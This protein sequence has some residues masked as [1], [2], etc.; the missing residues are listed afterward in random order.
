MH[1]Y[2]PNRASSTTFE[3]EPSGCRVSS[4]RLAQKARQGPFPVWLLSTSCIF[5]SHASPRLSPRLFSAQP[6]VV[7]PRATMWYLVEEKEPPKFPAQRKAC[8][9]YWLGGVRGGGRTIGRKHVDIRLKASSV[10]RTHARINVLK[11]AFYSP[12]SFGRRRHYST[13]VSVQDSSAY[14][15]FVKYPPGHASNRS[16]QAIGHHRRLDK[17][18]PTEVCEGALLAFGAPSSWWRLG[19]EHIVLVYTRISA[20]ERDRITLI[21]G[22]TAV[23]VAD[24]WVVGCT[25]LVTHECISSSMTFLAVL[26]EGKYVITP[27]WVEALRHTVTEACRAVTEAAN[28]EAAM[29]ACTLADE[30]RFIP[31]FSPADQ[32]AFSAEE[33]NAV[34]EPDVKERRMAMFK[35]IVFAFTREER[36]SRWVAVIETL[37]G[38]TMLARAVKPAGTTD[39]IVFV[40]G[41]QGASKKGLDSLDV[42]GHAYV[43]ESALSAAI[44]RADLSP[45]EDATS[46]VKPAVAEVTD[47]ATPGPL[48]SESE[49]ETDDSEPSGPTKRRT[50]GQGSAMEVEEAIVDVDGVAAG[51][52]DL[53]RSFAVPKASGRLPTVG[54]VKE[55]SQKDPPRTA[56]FSTAAKKRAR[57]AASISPENPGSPDV[58]RSAVD[59]SE[60]PDDVEKN[61]VTPIASVPAVDNSDVNQRAFFKV[62]EMGSPA[63]V[64]QAKRAKKASTLSSRDVRPFRRRKL[65]EVS[66]LPLK[67]VRCVENAESGFER[68]AAQLESR[69]GGHSGNSGA[70]VIDSEEE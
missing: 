3:A 34:F 17:D 35:G 58:K 10:S 29:A 55:A 51:A 68:A 48:D 47:V 20:P 41:E 50:S 45:L 4:P 23:E 61:Q 8:P 36:R 7:V 1:F 70:Q 28:E 27:A 6:F 63:N 37:G 2:Q 60:A 11:A 42:P 67:R 62:E 44:I 43:Q 21:A 24:T 9:R 26:A 65:P 49:A 54:D 57:A 39:R 38:A 19:W 40:Q 25:H 15:T 18:T 12:S 59:V 46:P 16:E 53:S 52:Q 14:G 33:L 13:C 64:V 69:R 22:Q 31:P 30:K 32:A 56:G 5:S 66:I